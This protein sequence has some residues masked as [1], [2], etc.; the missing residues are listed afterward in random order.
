[1]GYTWAAWHLM[2]V[3]RDDLQTLKI[4]QNCGHSVPSGNPDFGSEVA[5]VDRMLRISLFLIY[6]YIHFGQGMYDFRSL[7]TFNRHFTNQVPT[8]TKPL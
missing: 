3:S 6:G 4:P 2:L 5:A 7:R 8:A 1:M